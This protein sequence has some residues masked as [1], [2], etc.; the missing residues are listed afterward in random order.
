M[1]AQINEIKRMQQ[2]AGVLK[3]DQFSTMNNIMAVIS[4]LLE[5]GDEG[6]KVLD[7]LEKIPEWNDLV[8][9]NQDIDIKDK[10]I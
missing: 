7:I 2:L 4:Q 10:N 1:K 8:K 5:M 6:K 9:D 3:E